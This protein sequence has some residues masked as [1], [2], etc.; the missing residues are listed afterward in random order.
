MDKLN[1]NSHIEQ[2]QVISFSHWDYLNILPKEVINS[3]NSVNR[4]LN[5]ENI[6]PKFAFYYDYLN[7]ELEIKEYLL[8]SPL[9]GH[10]KVVMTISSDRPIISMNTNYFIENWCEFVTIARDQC[11]VWSPDKSL[12]LEFNS[13]EKKLFSNFEIKASTSI[14]ND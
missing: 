11:I 6:N 8:K 14:Y 13:Y 3:D 12:L 4:F 9:I 10:D 2:V 5:W 1:L 7:N